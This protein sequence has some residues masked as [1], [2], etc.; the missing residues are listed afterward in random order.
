MNTAGR[1]SKPPRPVPPRKSVRRTSGTLSGE[2]NTSASEG[3]IATTFSG[4]PT[5]SQGTLG[6]DT[7]SHHEDEF[8][9]LI[10]QIAV[11]RFGRAIMLVIYSLFGG[12]LFIT[13]EGSSD[14]M[15]VTAEGELS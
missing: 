8:I 14:T 2:G 15:V 6:T 5:E 3:T 1:V 12:V 9:G 11:T 13:I 7:S 10:K 4:P